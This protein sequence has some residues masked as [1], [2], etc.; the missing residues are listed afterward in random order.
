MVPCSAD[1]AIPAVLVIAPLFTGSAMAT[2]VAPRALHC[3]NLNSKFQP[4]FLVRMTALDE[5]NAETAQER[6]SDTLDQR[7]YKSGGEYRLPTANL[8]EP[9]YSRAHLI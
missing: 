8:E 5:V 3:G 2:E 1:L 7:G 4:H 9:D 6:N